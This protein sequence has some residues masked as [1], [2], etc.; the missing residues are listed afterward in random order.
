MFMLQDMLEM[1]HLKW[2]VSLIFSN[3]IKKKKANPNSIKQAINSTSSWVCIF[4]ESHVAI[5]ESHLLHLLLWYMKTQRPSF[6]YHDFK[7]HRKIYS[8][9]NCKENLWLNSPFSCWWNWK[10]NF[11]KLVLKLRKLRDNDLEKEKES[12]T[13]F[14]KSFITA[15][16][17]HRNSPFVL[18]CWICSASIQHLGS[19]FCG[20]LS[21]KAQNR[22]HLSAHIRKHCTY[23]LL[24]KYQMCH[25]FLLKH[26]FTRI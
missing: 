4:T 11:L 25:N 17:C 3:H 26:G 20:L 23:K 16:P 19:P 8:Y 1:K 13:V 21:H 15:D 10:C 7:H 6:I 18:F 2:M 5:T 12:W 22:N 9:P 24:W 14:T